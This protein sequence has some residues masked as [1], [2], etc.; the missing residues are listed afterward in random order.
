[1]VGLVW[2]GLV[3]WVG[4][5]VVADAGWLVAGSRATGRGSTT[6]STSS[7]F[8]AK[9]SGRWCFGSKLI[10]S[11]RT[12]G[13][14]PIPL[15][16][17]PLPLP[18][19]TSNPRPVCC[20]AGSIRPNRQCLP[21]LF[22]HE[23]RSR[24]PGGPA[25]PTGN[26]PRFFSPQPRSLT[27]PPVPLGP[28]RH[29]PRRARS[30]RHHS[31]RPGRDKRAARRRLPDQDCHGSPR[32][33]EQNLITTT[34]ARTHVQ[35]QHDTS[36]VRNRAARVHACCACTA[37]TNHQPKAALLNGPPARPR[38]LVG[39]EGSADALSEHSYLPCLHNH[40]G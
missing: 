28:L 15:P 20:S 26:L 24:Q 16:S 35:S 30:S 6:R 34:H 23:R 32:G 13:W 29:R 4:W 36:S 1:M 22:P 5:W 39:E 14:V 9:T 27:K 38:Q 11:R 37:P 8:S 10:T 33:D 25:C 31:H 18:T 2:V 21:A 12:I 40:T 17:P 19:R 7:S 3:C